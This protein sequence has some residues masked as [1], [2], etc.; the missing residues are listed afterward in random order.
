MKLMAIRVLV[1]VGESV[2]RPELTVFDL[3]AMIGEVMHA[4]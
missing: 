3:G 2:D 4:Q 1:P